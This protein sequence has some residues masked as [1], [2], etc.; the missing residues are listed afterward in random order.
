M[1]E[2]TRAIAT[3][4]NLALHGL[5]NFGTTAVLLNI[6]N[7]RA[8]IFTCDFGHGHLLRGA[9]GRLSSDAMNGSKDTTNATSSIVNL[10]PY[11]SR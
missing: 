9:Y 4:W 2:Q 8:L 6:P 11:D 5:R 1:N 10:G 7:S 3:T